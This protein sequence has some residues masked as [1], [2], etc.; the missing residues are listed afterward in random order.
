MDRR[1]SN[2]M[3]GTC[4]NWTVLIVDEHRCSYKPIT[5]V[6]T[7]RYPNTE[8]MLEDVEHAVKKALCDQESFL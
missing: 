3:Y 4:I 7:V 5:S 1:V 8:R 2:G 6:F